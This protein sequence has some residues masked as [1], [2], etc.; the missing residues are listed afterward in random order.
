MIRRQHNT[1]SAWLVRRAGGQRFDRVSP[2]T[3]RGQLAERLDAG[4][5]IKIEKPRLT[6]TPSGSVRESKPIPSFIHDFQPGVLP[7]FLHK[8]PVP[9][10]P[11]SCQAHYI[12]TSYRDPG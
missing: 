6:P 1:F 5:E 3:H 8:P 2:E 7:T 9:Q 12:V 4:F 10:K 11:L